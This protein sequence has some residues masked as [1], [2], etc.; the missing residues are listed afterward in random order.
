MKYKKTN[1][2]YTSQR[3]FDDY[4]S[5]R[6]FSTKFMHKIKSNWEEKKRMSRTWC[7][8]KFRNMINY[9]PENRKYLYNM[10]DIYIWH[11]NKPHIWVW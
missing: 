3:T 5:Q 6:T 4:T 9:R 8:S 2:N 7:V 11:V 10:K 1:D